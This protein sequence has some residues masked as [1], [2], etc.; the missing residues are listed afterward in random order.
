M[1]SVLVAT[2]FI[3]ALFIFVI[4]VGLY[5][6]SGEAIE[7]ARHF[8]YCLWTCLA[9]LI[10]EATAYILDGHVE[11]T[12]LITIANY[13]AYVLIDVLICFYGL[14]L[15]TM[16]PDGEKVI[17]RRIAILLG[18]LCSLDVLIQTYGTISGQLFYVKDGS[19]YNGPWAP[20]SVLIPAL[21]FLSTIFLVLKIYRFFG[22][23]N[24]LI[25][26]LL[27]FVPGLS[28]AVVFYFSALQHGFI[29]AA[30]SLEVIYVMLQS[31]IVAEANFNAQ[32]YNELSTKD[33]LTGLKNRR[34]YLDALESLP[35]E[36]SVGVVF[37]DVN[38]L[39][40]VNDS[41]GHAAG[42]QLIITVANLLRSS[43]P[44][45]IDCRIS[46]DEFVCLLPKVD[47]ERF[48]SRMDALGVLLRTHNQ[49]ASYGY[50]LGSGASALDTIKDA[51]NMMYLDKERYYSET[52]RDRRR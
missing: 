19:I 22:I 49:I 24:P 5:Q 20:Y 46:G 1:F 35:P 2:N 42:D 9:G 6:V 34:G 4:I 31:K 47:L 11:Y 18:S 7:K 12:H 3:S 41:Q 48:Q 21:C 15:Y 30:L 10:L 32:R 43:F 37:C 26:L 28:T 13:L 17:S 44:D 33:A 29:G 40:A 52:G 36:D 23:T 51:E 45:G 14:Y 39:K 50:A 8:R 25:L 38:S 27:V 16:F